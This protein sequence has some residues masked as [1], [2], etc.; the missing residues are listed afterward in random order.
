[1][2]PIVNYDGILSVEKRE[3]GFYYV[4]FKP[5]SSPDNPFNLGRFPGVPIEVE[6][7]LK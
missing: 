6:R 1:M 3:D 2:N 4:L 5:E 7:A